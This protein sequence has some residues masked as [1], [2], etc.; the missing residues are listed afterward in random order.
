MVAM[1]R[2]DAVTPHSLLLGF[3]VLNQTKVDSIMSDDM[4]CALS[5]SATFSASPIRYRPIFEPMAVVLLLALLPV[6]SLLAAYGSRSPVGLAACDEF[7]GSPCTE[8]GSL[9]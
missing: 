8:F 7:T 6:M 2:T 9:P 4:M 5:L 3:L 1:F